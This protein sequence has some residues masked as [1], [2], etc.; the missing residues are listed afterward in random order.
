MKYQDYYQTLRVDRDADAAT[1]KKAYRKLARQFHP[2]VSV[3][4]DAEEKFKAVGEAYEV[5][6]DEEKRA[7]YD[8]LGHNW[9]A[10]QDF[11]PPPGWQGAGSDNG[12]A[13]AS[14]D[15]DSFADLF[16]DLY[17][18]GGY[19]GAQQ[20][21]L[22]LHATL[23]LTLEEL[24]AGAPVDL[25]LRDPSSGEERRLR[26]K[27]PTHLRDGESFRLKGQGRSQAGAPG[28][29]G[30]LYVEIRLVPHPRFEVKGNDIHSQLEITP[31]EAVLGTKIPVE[32]LGGMVNLAIPP[33]SQTGTQL[34]LKNR[35]LAGSNPGHQIVTLKVCV[36]TS[37]S[38]EELE[39]Y[40]A[41]ADISSF[42]PRAS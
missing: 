25:H 24:F 7:A 39:H 11:Q 16:N 27:V 17:G 15:L 38:D 9:Q 6:K 32:T 18:R 37:L 33:R 26:V 30:N 1:I 34:R 3:E 10:G 4:T 19:Q 20:A 8:Q 23:G 42:D 22:D 13:E 2:D 28:T 35:G 29:P 31:W 12:Y 5:L 14:F 41:L 36:P 21:N 40:K